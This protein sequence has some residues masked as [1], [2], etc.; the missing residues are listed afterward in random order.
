MG[1]S[2]VATPNSVARIAC[3]GGIVKTAIATRIAAASAINAARCAWTLPEASRTRSVTT[4][5]AAT[6]VDSA[7]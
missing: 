1:K 2:P 6:S 7:C 5:I 4:G 3:P